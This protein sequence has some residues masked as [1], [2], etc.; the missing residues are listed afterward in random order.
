MADA[1]GRLGEP[2]ALHRAEGLGV[3]IDGSGR[4]DH[5]QVREGLVQSV[6]WSGW[7]GWG[8]WGGFGS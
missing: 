5:P 6:Q 8:G 3:E 1:A 4:A 2:E 7:G